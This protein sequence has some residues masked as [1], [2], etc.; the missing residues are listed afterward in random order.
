MLEPISFV[1][2]L[3]GGLL[4]KPNLDSF[5]AD[6]DLSTMNK[7]TDEMVAEVDKALLAID[8]YERGDTVVI[9]EGDGVVF[10]WD[11]TSVGGAE[12]LGSRGTDLR[13]DQRSR[14]TRAE[15]REAFHARKDAE[16]EV[17]REM[18]AERRAGVWTAD[19]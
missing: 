12:L 5:A 15:K 18:E 19:D 17:R 9:G 8:G 1:W 13:L 16:S 2:P 3:A 4:G 11:P 6:F 14:P 10:D 7:V